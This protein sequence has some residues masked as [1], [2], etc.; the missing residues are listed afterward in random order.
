MSPPDP[1]SDPP[2]PKPDASASGSIVSPDHTRVFAALAIGLLVLVGGTALLQRGPAESPAG[3]TEPVRYRINVNAAPAAS[4]ELL[5]GIG[6][7]YAG[8]IVRHRREQGPFR[9]LAD[10]REIR[11]IG[12]K[13]SKQVA[14]YIRFGPLERQTDEED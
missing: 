4:L 3:P 1:A 2:S 5:S 6:P 7:T 14:P 12:P 11:G 8:R 9:S 10:L 13:R